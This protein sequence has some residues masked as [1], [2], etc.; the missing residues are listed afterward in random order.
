MSAVRNV[1]LALAVSAGALIAAPAQATTTRTVS[2][3]E[4]TGFWWTDTFYLSSSAYSL[5]LDLQ[6]NYGNVISSIAAFLAHDDFSAVNNL[7]VSTAVRPGKTSSSETSVPFFVATSGLYRVILYGS[8]F[9]NIGTI[10]PSSNLA[11]AT[12]KVDTATITTPGPIAGA[13]VPAVLG[14]MGF[15]AWRRRKAA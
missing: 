11:T 2:I 8:A 6:Q 13:G 3:G 15:A 5:T 10:G 1:V 14:L 4:T 9:Y 7:D 12:V